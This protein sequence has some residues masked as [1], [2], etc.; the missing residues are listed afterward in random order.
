MISSKITKPA[1]ILIS[2]C[3][4]LPLFAAEPNEPN[5][6]ATELKILK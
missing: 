1:I 5:K 4:L 3:I 6:P 2:A